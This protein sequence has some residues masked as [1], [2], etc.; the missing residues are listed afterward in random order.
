M[1]FLGATSFFGFLGGVVSESSNTNT[2]AYIKSTTIKTQQR[3]PMPINTISTI[4]LMI[5]EN[6][7]L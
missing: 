1:T 4:T 7:E 6:R 2:V 3:Y 5:I